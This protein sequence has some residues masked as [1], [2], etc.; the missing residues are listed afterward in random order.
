[1]TAAQFEQLDETEAV[2]VLRW[3][4]DVLLRAGFDFEQAATVAAHV[5]VDLHRAV[6]LI[7]RGCPTE[8]A[9]RI[10]V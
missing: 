5:D 7:D 8:T 4:F 6:E 1:M 3:R 10:L 2:G 9:I